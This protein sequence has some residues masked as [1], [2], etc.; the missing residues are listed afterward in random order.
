LQHIHALNG[1]LFKIK[2]RYNHKIAGSNEKWGKE[3]IAKE[4]TK[5]LKLR[6]ED[7]VYTVGH[8]GIRR[9]WLLTRIFK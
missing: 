3:K 4:P 8:N 6:Q 1:S 7:N 2:S 5:I 9:A